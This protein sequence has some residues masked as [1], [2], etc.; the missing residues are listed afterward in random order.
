MNAVLLLVP[1]PRVRWSLV[2]R[3]LEAACDL[4]GNE[5]RGGWEGLSDFVPEAWGWDDQKVLESGYSPAEVFQN[6]E[7]STH[8]MLA[9][10]RSLCPL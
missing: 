5:A 6:E 4:D 7:V 10:S 1:V 3:I 2:E 9:P 8:P